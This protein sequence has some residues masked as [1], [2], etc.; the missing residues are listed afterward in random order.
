MLLWRYYPICRTN[1]RR[2]SRKRVV[3]GSMRQMSGGGD[4]QTGGKE[5]LLSAGFAQHDSRAAAG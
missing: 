2:E 4:G 5:V 1:E 3:R